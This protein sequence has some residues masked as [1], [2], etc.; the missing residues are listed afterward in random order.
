MKIAV[1]ACLLG[2][3]CRYDGAS[4]PCSCVQ[5]LQEHHELIP[6]CPEVAGGMQVPHPANEI[7]TNQHELCVKDTEG[8]D[9]T[10]AFVRG[11]Q[12]TLEQVKREGC[13]LAILKAKSPSC[14]NGLIY[15]GTFTQ[16][17][18][19][20]YGVAARLLRA[21][22]IRVIDE[23]QL[24]ACCQAGDSISQLLTLSSACD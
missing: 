5:A 9:N 24:E 3:A 21:E 22:G 13:Q 16:T 7:M 4:K 17:L 20:G 2:T 11:A 18:V 23:K 8:H 6:V 10:D 14:G 15:D 19:P 1:S 12:K